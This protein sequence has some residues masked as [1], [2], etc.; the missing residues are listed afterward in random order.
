L[1]LIVCPAHTEP[2]GTVAATAEADPADFEAMA[3]E[4]NC[5]AETQRLLGGSSLKVAF[6]QAGAQHL[7]SDVS[8]G[9][10]IPSPQQNSEKKFF[11]FA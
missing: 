9:V 5:C 2:S 7:V 8:I 6:Q 3:T 10:F 4:Q 11:A 1:L